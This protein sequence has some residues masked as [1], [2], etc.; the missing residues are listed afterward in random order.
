MTKEKLDNKQSSKN[1]A[2]RFLHT[3]A[4]LN[5]RACTREKVHAKS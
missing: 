1:I 5:I 4:F 2:K 3:Q